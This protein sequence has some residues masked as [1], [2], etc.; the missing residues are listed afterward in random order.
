MAGLTAAQIVT[1]STQVAKT[2][3]MTSQAGQLLNAIL[4]E[5]CQN[6][7]FELASIAYAFSFTGISGPYA[8]PADYLRM[9][10]DTFIFTIDGVP[11]VLPQV[12]YPQYLAM[13]QTAG[14]QSYPTCFATDPSTTPTN[15]YVWPPP[16]GAYPV[17]ME[18]YRAMADIATPESSSA[19]PWFPNQTYLLRRLAGELM[20]IASDQRAN[21]FLGDN[22]ELYPQGAGTI[23]RKYMRMKDDELGFVKTVSLD[24]RMFGSPFRGLKNTKLVGW[25]VSLTCALSLFAELHRVGGA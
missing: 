24:P 9:K 13:V 16:S 19:V 12:D 5:L 23:L 15:L 17:T 8:M 22:D 25:A 18:Y 7:N 4:A 21:G 20:L 11:Y 10:K 2:P 14:F 6:F 3:G 1:L